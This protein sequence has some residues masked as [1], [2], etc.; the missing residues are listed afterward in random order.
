MKKYLLLAVVGV[1][2]I[3]VAASRALAFGGCV[4]SPEN[5]SVVLG[6][7][8]AA[9]AAAPLIRSRLNSRASRERRR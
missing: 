2:A 8:V 6:L 5:P 7:I 3:G 9:V 1:V 4:D